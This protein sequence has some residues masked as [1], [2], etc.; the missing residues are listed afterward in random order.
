MEI[1][2]I[3]IFIAEFFRNEFKFHCSEGVDFTPV[4]RV[5]CTK[6]TEYQGILSKYR[7]V[8]A[9]VYILAQVTLIEMVLPGPQF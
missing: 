4:T 6:E 2:N 5:F 8:L 9:Q 1:T 7:T 3:A